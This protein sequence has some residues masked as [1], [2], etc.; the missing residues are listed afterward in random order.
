MA[1]PI[2]TIE[3]TAD[4]V[5]EVSAR[6][7]TASEQVEAAKLMQRIAPAL[8]EFDRAMRV[9][10]DTSMQPEAEVRS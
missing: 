1:T 5:Q 8:D 2:V 4:G 3:L 9:Q 10:L 7:R 6:I